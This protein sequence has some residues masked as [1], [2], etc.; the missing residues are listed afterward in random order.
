MRAPSSLGLIE[1]RSHRSSSRR[2]ASICKCSK[3][4]PS[5][6]IGGIGITFTLL[7]SRSSSAGSCA[8]KKEGR[9]FASD[10]G[11]GGTIQYVQKTT[12]GSLV[13]RAI[14]IAC[15]FGVCG[16]PRKNRISIAKDILSAVISV[17][18]KVSYII[19]LYNKLFSPLF[20]SLAQL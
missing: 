7:A 11:V 17:P 9:Y 19:Q 12:R 3:L 13:L 16:S 10:N 20:Q 5:S 18:V 14:K 8:A 2:S 15:P 1:P 6:N 4:L